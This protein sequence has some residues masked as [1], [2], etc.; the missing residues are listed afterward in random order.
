MFDAIKCRAS[1]DLYSQTSFL[2]YHD[3]VLCAV[4]CNIAPHATDKFKTNGALFCCTCRYLNALE[5]DS[6][7]FASSVEREVLR[8]HQDLVPVLKNKQRKSNCKDHFLKHTIFILCFP[9]LL[10][11]LIYIHI[12]S[13]P[14]S[15]HFM[16]NSRWYI[17]FEER[18][19][20]LWSSCTVSAHW[21][22]QVSQYIPFC[23]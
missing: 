21:S 6:E 17:G 3:N 2:F 7:A 1:L 19:Y 9:L 20:G 23:L 10:S 12:Y 11:G 8:N 18:I 16:W 22:V 14:P 4:C 15:N 13:P 5:V